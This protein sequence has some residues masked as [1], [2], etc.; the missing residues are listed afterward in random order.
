MKRLFNESMASDSKLVASVVVDECKDMFSGVKCLVD[1]GG[2]T[3]ALATAIAQAVLFLIFH[4][5]LTVSN[6][7]VSIL[8]LLGVTCSPI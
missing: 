1:V 5:S 7:I 8:C 2:G 4:M 6:M 3:R